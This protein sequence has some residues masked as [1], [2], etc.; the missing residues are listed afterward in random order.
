[1]LARSFPIK[2]RKRLAHDVIDAC[3]THAGLSHDV[4][5]T[6]CQTQLDSAQGRVFAI[7]KKQ[8]RPQI[9]RKSVMGFIL[10]VF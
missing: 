9:D 4:T 7:F 8:I 10:I 1:M 6:D 3:A 2:D 5:D